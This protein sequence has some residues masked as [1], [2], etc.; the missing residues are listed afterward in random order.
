[1]ISLNLENFKKHLKNANLVPVFKEI[2]LDYD[3]P[4]SILQ[5]INKNKYCFLLESSNGPEK[6]SRFSFMGF[7]PKMIISSHG[8]KN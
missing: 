3:N 6:W 8:E 5:K 7:N 2:D 1:M 4:L